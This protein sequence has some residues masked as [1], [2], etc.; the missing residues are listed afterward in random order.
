M[1]DKKLT[2]L[3]WEDVRIFVS[4]ARYGSLSAAAR[5]LSL[6]HATISRRIQSLEHTLKE[7]LVERRPDGY[8]LT[9]AGTHVL[10]SA[11]EMEVAAARLIRGGSDDKPKGLVRVNSSPSLTQSFLVPR[12]AKLAVEHP[13]LDINITTDLR[14][15]SLER[16]E[17]DIALRLG[18]PLDGDVLAKK[19]ASIG[20]GFYATKE[21]CQRIK[22]G[23]APEFCC[24]D[25]LNAHLPEAEWLLQ[26][27]PRTR[28]AFRANNQ[29]AQAAGA[30]QGAGIAMLPHFIGRTSK[31][32]HHCPL[33]HMPPSRGVWLLTR[34]QDRR[35][36]S[37]RTVVE[38]LTETFSTERALFE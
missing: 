14:N 31:L 1:A 36:L 25:E 20:F 30:E 27:F 3:D 22:K 32:L 13:L 21:W 8:V 10:S 33:E 38:F 6:T 17:T 15:V 35:D 37:I 16:H 29:I 7:K 19:V 26:H 18:K 34:P 12:L 4:L 24:F 28:L 23:T 5:A 2:T 11:N 9:P